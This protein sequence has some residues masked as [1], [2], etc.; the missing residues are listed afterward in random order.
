MAYNN[1]CVDRGQNCTRI[2]WFS[3]PTVLA[4]GNV[5]IGK[6]RGK[7]GAADNTR[8]L[9]QTRTPISQYE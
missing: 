8:R 6:A 3:S 5:V 1:Y 4:T 9:K 7:A 2:N